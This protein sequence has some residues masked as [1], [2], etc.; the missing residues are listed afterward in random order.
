VPYLL[1][2]PQERLDYTFDWGPFLDEA[3]SPSDTIAASSWFVVPANAGSPSEPVIESE[4]N[5]VSTATVFLR[6]C[7]AG[8]LYRLTN[9]VTTSSGRKAERS[10]TIRC[11]Q[12]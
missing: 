7:E 9:R 8:A 11:E 2:D 5:T 6:N 3:G 10:M 12:I 1:I 4:S